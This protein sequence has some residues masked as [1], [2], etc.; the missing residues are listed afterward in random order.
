MTGT[1]SASMDTASNFGDLRQQLHV[2]RDN[3]GYISLG[4]ILG[5]SHGN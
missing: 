3:N 2:V 1:I 5:F 4:T